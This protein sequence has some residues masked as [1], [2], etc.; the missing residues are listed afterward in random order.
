MVV[1][2]YV[3]AQSFQDQ[4]I[5]GQT[6]RPQSCGVQNQGHMNVF[7]CLPDRV[8]FNPFLLNLWIAPYFPIS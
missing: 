3:R 4:A 5:T 7:I 1:R 8:Q 6:K 2:D